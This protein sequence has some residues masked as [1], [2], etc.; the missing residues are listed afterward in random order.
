MLSGNGTVKIGDFGQSQFFGRRD[1]F[2]RTLG[3]PAYL[4]AWPGSWR[5]GVALWEQPW[6]PQ[7]LVLFGLLQPSRCA[8]GSLTAVLKYPSPPPALRPAPEVCAGESYRGRQADI[9]ALGVSLYLFIF[10]EL[11]FKVGRW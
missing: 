1:V 10:G 6:A 11:P 5:L 8:A 2:N 3:T 9:W 7:L 4:G